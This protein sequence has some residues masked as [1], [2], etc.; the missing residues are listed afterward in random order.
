MSD[1]TLTLSKLLSGSVIGNAA[2]E[3]A[4]V[5][6]FP[7]ETAHLMALCHASWAV[8]S[9]YRVSFYDGGSIPT[10][11]FYM[12]EARSG[13]GKSRVMKMLSRGFGDAI[14]EERIN[15][16]KKRKELLDKFNENTEGKPE[17]AS[18]HEKDAL[19]SDLLKHHAVSQGASDITGAA[20]DNMLKEQQGWFVLKTTEQ[21]LIDSLFLGAHTDGQTNIDPILNAFDGEM[22]DT[23]RITREGFHGIPH[24]GIGLI[25]QDGL[26]EK[27]LGASG[28]RGLTQRFFMVIEPTMM[29]RRTFSRYS[30]KTDALDKFNGL[31]KHVTEDGIKTVGVMSYD[32]LF[33]L[34]I[35]DEGW[36]YIYEY[37]NK[38]EPLLGP[39]GRYEPAILSSMWSKIELF[40]M[41]VA[42]TLHVIEEMNSEEKEI[43]A[44]TVASAIAIVNCMFKG[45]SDI[46]ERKGIVGVS[47][48]ERAALE[49]M[50][51]KGRIKGLDIQAIKNTLT[52]RKVFA[53]YQDNK[54]KRVEDVIHALCEKGKLSFQVIDGT[55]Y[56]RF[57]KF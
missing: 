26:I 27:I 53:E 52:R 4:D 48:E 11:L 37:K 35:S 3:A 44:V 41:K 14:E 57:V 38:I 42:S 54:S 7:A 15:R 46:A 8:G 13:E 45:V 22:M 40:T 20:F 21:G 5:A 51:S 55:K 25:S 10:N 29:G 17:K 2:Q 47:I 24:G 39:G 34:K 31:C 18:R 32:N 12:A 1:T 50:E 56:Y 16:H 28:N 6:K 36:D 9:R 49:Y 33:T 43:E 19:E 30:K 23:Q